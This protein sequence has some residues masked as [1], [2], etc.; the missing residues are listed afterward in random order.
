MAVLRLT[1][2]LRF[3]AVRARMISTAI[4]VLAASSAGVPIA[5]AALASTGSAAYSS[6]SAGY[7]ISGRWFRYIQAEV[8]L[9]TD[10]A[11]AQ[12]YQVVH[13]TSA[14]GSFSIIAELGSAQDSRLEDVI[15]DVPTSTGC[16]TYS[17]AFIDDGI[18]FPL[19][20]ALLSPGDNIVLSVYYDQQNFGVS[21]KVTDLANGQT[22]EVDATNGASSVYTSAQVVG[23][24]GSFT[25][26]ANQFRV[27]PFT[28]AAATTFTGDHGTMTGPWTTSQVVMTS[29]GKSSGIV[30]AN[31]P[32]LWDGGRN[33]STWVQPR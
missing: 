1:R 31:S 14:T 26:P 20:A 16:G 13:N 15:S 33:F 6:T 9:P 32:V 24:F 19:D 25:A 23:G 22:L 28:D 11:C 27:L 7:M 21:G 18:G 29:N 2:A 30:E 17:G 3:H 8:P 4:I 5:T 10:S 12:L